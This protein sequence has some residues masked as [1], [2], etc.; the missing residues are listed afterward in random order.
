[1]SA[2]LIL[3]VKDTAHFDRI[4][5]N[6][7]DNGQRRFYHATRIAKL[8]YNINKLDSVTKLC[9]HRASVKIKTRMILSKRIRKSYKSFLRKV[10]TVLWL[11]LSLIVSVVRKY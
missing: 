5:Q 11:R 9:G 10:E 1:M 4:H 7:N 6:V 3:E 2:I 8:F